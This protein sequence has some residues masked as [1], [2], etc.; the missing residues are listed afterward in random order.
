MPATCVSNGRGLYVNDLVSLLF[1][2]CIFLTCFLSQVEPSR[3]LVVL[4]GGGDGSSNNLTQIAGN[5]SGS[6][7]FKH[8]IGNVCSK[9]DI[10]V[11]QKF[12]YPLPNGIPAFNV[13]ITNTCESGCAIKN[14]R[15]RCGAFASA[16]EV[17]PKLFR[18]VAYDNCL[19]NDGKK[20]K[21]GDTVSF[22]YANSFIYRL[23]V[24]SVK[25]NA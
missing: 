20:L 8:I 14:I 6:F 1:A 16:V 21:A 7:G 18:R 4:N 25:C 3:Q 11:S 2:V 5:N 13:H 15:I 9:R 19:V 23:T 10:K 12:V 17:N 24:A 22:R